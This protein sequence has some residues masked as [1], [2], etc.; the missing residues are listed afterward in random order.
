MKVYRVFV[1]EHNS[2]QETQGHEFYVEEKDERSA[3]LKVLTS[4]AVPTSFGSVHVSERTA[5]VIL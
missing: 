2:A 1:R 3:I 4:G 5:A